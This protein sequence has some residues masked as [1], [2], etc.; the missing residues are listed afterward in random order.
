MI[1]GS[2]IKQGISVKIVLILMV[3]FWWKPAFPQDPGLPDS[4]IIHSE[5]QIPYNS[6]ETSYIWIDVDFVVDDTLVAFILPLKWISTDNQI[7]PIDIRHYWPPHGFY[8]DSISID[9]SSFTISY[10]PDLGD[11]LGI[12]N[13]GGQRLNLF[14]VEF[15]ILPEAWNQRVVM[16]TAY[17]PT[18]GEMVFFIP[19]A[20]SFVAFSPVFVSGGFIYGDQEGISDQD[21]LPSGNILNYPNPLGLLKKPLFSLLSA[22]QSQICI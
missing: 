1:A 14:D 22:F 10:S 15:E 18:D 3:I 6:N 9:G 16:D 12:V 17:S 11:S 2:F 20:D 4:V 7:R 19:Q 21:Q 8:T 13:T 5:Y